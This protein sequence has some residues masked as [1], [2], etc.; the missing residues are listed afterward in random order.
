VAGGRRRVPAGLGLQSRKIRP[1]KGE[2]ISLVD[3]GSRG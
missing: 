3:T 2:A 1:G